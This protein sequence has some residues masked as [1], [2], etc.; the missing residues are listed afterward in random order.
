MVIKCKRCGGQVMAGWASIRERDAVVFTCLQCG[1]EH[2]ADG[3]LVAT[4]KNTSVRI[5]DPRHMASQNKQKHQR[6]GRTWQF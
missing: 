4:H 3:E 6:M 1:R 5:I 2:T